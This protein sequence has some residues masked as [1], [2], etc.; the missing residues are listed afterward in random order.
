[1]LPLDEGECACATSITK[2]ALDAPISSA[3]SSNA[4]DRWTH[5]RAEVIE[6][7]VRDEK[8]VAL[9]FSGGTDSL[10]LAQDLLAAGARARFFC[11]AVTPEARDARRASAAAGR[12]DL[13]LELAIVTDDE[14]RACLERLGEFPPGL[15]GTTQRVLAIAETLLAEVALRLGAEELWTGHGPEAVLGGFH[16]RRD[17]GPDE[18]ARM[19]ASIELNAGRLNRVALAHSDS[20]LVFVH[21]FLHPRLLAAA[22]GL[23][24]AGVTHRDLAHQDSLP[25]AALQNGSGIHYRL[26]RCARA[27]GFR[28]LGAW[29]ANRL[30]QPVA[31]RSPARTAVSAP[32]S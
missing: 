11:L 3:A 23:R 29:F 9:A 25:K 32:A 6:N 22:R 20:G 5:E 30:D 17:P 13:R 15:V 26:E 8:P 2:A 12:L 10:M 7:L 28:T 1:M 4:V 21:P 14:L 24:S 31:D 18:N 19:A 16:R 27:D